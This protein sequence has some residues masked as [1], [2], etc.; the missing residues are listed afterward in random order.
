MKPLDVKYDE[1]TD[2][3]DICGIRYSGALFRV[4]GYGPLGTW[5]RIEGRN[6]GAV[7]LRQFSKELQAKFE[8]AA[9]LKAIR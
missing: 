2:V 9:N 4:I 8:Q 3:L 6:D 5:L 7:T 1:D